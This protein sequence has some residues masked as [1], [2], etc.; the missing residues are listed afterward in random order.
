METRGLFLAALSNLVVQLPVLVVWVVGFI[1][2]ASRWQ[3][4]RKVSLFV[5]LGLSILL[6]T[7]LAGGWLSVWLP[8]RMRGTSGSLARLGV[9]L[10]SS[11][12]LI[13]VIGAVGWGL[14]I[15][16]VFR[17]RET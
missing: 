3:R 12:L 1:L 17:G 10:F 2:A 13:S 5:V 9:I 16:A 14:L 8:Q 6:I 11:R 4:H 15:A 7:M